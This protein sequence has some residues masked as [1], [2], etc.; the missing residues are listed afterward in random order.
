LDAWVV[1]NQLRFDNILHVVDKFINEVRVQLV[2]KNVTLEISDQARQ[3]LA[4]KGFDKLYG[5]RPMQRLIQQKIR[6]T[7]ADELLFGK[8]EHG[9]IAR[10]D[11]K[12]GE[13]TVVCTSA[14]VDAKPD[15]RV[16]RVETKAEPEAKNDFEKPGSKSDGDTVIAD[17]APVP[18]ES[19]RFL[20]S[21]K[22][23]KQ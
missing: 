4:K 3:W 15:E 16:V 18:V 23:S 10:V 13:L 17:T 8:L 12:D 9:G 19:P 21:G 14:P 2:E 20:D 22:E 6:Q 5:A 1:F 11:E 7:L